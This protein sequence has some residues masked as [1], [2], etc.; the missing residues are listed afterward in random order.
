MVNLHITKP[1][2]AQ[3]SSYWFANVTFQRLF[4]TKRLSDYSLAIKILD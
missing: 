4:L 1:S 2:L 3:C